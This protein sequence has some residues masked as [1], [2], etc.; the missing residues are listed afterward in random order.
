MTEMQPPQGIVESLFDSRPVFDSREDIGAMTGYVERALRYFAGDPIRIVQVTSA[1]FNAPQ[2]LPDES[3]ARSALVHITG[4]PC[5]YGTDGTS[6]VLTNGQT[7]PVGTIFTLTGQPTL[8]GFQFAA[9][10]LVAC[11]ANVTFY[12]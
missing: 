5:F 10:A 4:A 9:I 12:D 11:I 8:R 6:P 2:G 1:S 7:V 3:R